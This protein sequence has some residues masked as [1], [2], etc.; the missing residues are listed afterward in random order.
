MLCLSDRDA[1]ALAAVLGQEPTSEMHV[2]D[3][4][5]PPD[6]HL[7]TKLVAA[8]VDQERTAIDLYAAEHYQEALDLLSAVILAHPSYASAYNNR[9]QAYRALDPV[10]P[11]AS[12]DLRQAV[13]LAT[14]RSRFLSKMQATVLKNA[15]AQLAAIYT[16]LAA[17]SD[18][19]LSWEYR[20]MAS[21]QLALAGSYGEKTLQALAVRVNPY[22]KL[23]GGV[24][25]QALKMDRDPM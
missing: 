2:V 15:H 23:C 10:D 1:Q 13:A 21:S 24:M 17:R 9:A 5:L 8:L 16:E 7:D 11:R 18:D 25:E 12:A 4:S 20:E 19:Q 22:A 14:P 6:Q 3:L